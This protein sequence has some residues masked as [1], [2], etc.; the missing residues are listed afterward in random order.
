MAMTEPL[1][2]QHDRRPLLFFSWFAFAVVA[3][4]TVILR[5][6]FYREE[7]TLA[8][9]G[10]AID[11]A[12]TLPLVWYLVAVRRG[13]ASL[14]TLG[15]LV[16]FGLIAAHVMTPGEPP[17]ILLALVGL[18]ELTIAIVVFVRVRHALRESNDAADPL[19]RIEAFARSMLPVPRVAKMLAS[20]LG[21]IWYAFGSW[22]QEPPEGE[23]VRRWAKVEDWW[24]VVIGLSVVVIAETI[25]IHLWLMTKWPT[26]V[27]VLTV[28]E[29]YG[30]VWIVADARALS[31]SAVRVHDDSV[32]LAFG[33][34]YRGVIARDD[35]ESIT[36]IDG[37]EKCWDVKL[38][39][40]EEPDTLITLRRPIEL[41][42]AYGFTKKARRI[43]LLL[44]D[45][46]VVSAL[47]TE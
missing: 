29:L 39:L 26:A 41:D 3:I 42:G 1:A 22:K 27:W 18:A 34:R 9:A 21:I 32:E 46:L 28:L 47:Q 13:K 4:W 43:A 25:G 11:L 19:A 44:E 15:P 14:L 31:L 35:I 7:P 6:S 36:R 2:L 40:V 8:A 38:A 24:G 12:V 45:S 37:T 33:F 17:A 5:G 23:N 10:V 30:I 16:V 20:E